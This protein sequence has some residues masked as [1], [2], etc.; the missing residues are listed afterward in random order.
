MIQNYMLLPFYELKSQQFR[1]RDNCNYG[2]EVHS[3]RIPKHM[4]PAFFFKREKR[5]QGINY[6]YVYDLND[7]I[8]ATIDPSVNLQT[9]STAEYDGFGYV[10]NRIENGLDV[11]ADNDPSDRNYNNFLLPCGKY[12]IKLSEADTIKSYY[13]EVFEVTDAAPI[14]DQMEL[15]LNGSF[16]DDLN[17]WLTNGTWVV[18]IGTVTY[19]GG[20]S[21]FILSQPINTVDDSH[22]FYKVSFVINAYNDSGDDTRYLRVYFNGDDALNSVVVKASGGYTYYVKNVSQLYIKHF[23][24]E[25]TFGI[26]S[27][28]VQKIV[29][30]EEHVSLL[31]ASEC[32]YPNSIDKEN[33]N[34]FNYFLLDALILEP[35]YAEVKKEEENGD[36]EKVLSF[37][38]PFKTHQITPMLLPEPVADALAQLN[39]FDIAELY[40]GTKN[41][42]FLLN[43]TEA[44]TK[45]RSIQSFETSFE[46]QA[47]RSCYMLAN[48][49]FEENLSILNRCCDDADGVVECFDADAGEW[50]QPEIAVTFVD[51]HFHIALSNTPTGLE[52][53]FVELFFK[54]Q[55]TEDYTNCDGVGTPSTVAGISVPY[56][57]FAENGIDFYHPDRAGYVFKFMAFFGQ[58]GCPDSFALSTEACQAPCMYINSIDGC[59]TSSVIGGHT[60]YVV[61]ADIDVNLCGDDDVI[62][63]LYNNDTSTWFEPAVNSYPLPEGAS[64]PEFVFDDT[65]AAVPG[66]I[67]KIRLRKGGLTSNEVNVTFG[68]C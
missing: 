19:T 12:Y 6:F 3:F 66:D 31:L 24:G 27:I 10:P 35:Q 54:R 46:W 62:V 58:I 59:Y 39:T 33:F 4:L 28:S 40:D 8:V 36:F 57:E 16:D 2:E 38:R 21:G 1:F 11:F 18:G 14:T 56:S 68:F 32:K 43:S 55:L 51:D 25:V 13:S 22:H 20:G 44:L 9:I 67:H 30:H 7:N 29:G 47:P 41:D 45:F 34:Y 48:I 52:A 60:V 50:I 61:H 23:N 5:A 49:S 17:N 53:S 42:L 65:N 15:I 63:E 64:S 37:S 26:H